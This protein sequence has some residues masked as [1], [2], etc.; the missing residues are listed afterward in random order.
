[1]NKRKHMPGFVS[2]VGAGP[3]DPEL[4]T[5]KAFRRLQNADLVLYDALVEA[6]ILS[7]APAAQR[8]CVGKRA[9]H[10]SVSQ[11]TIEGLLIRGAKTGKQVVRLKCG[12]PFVLGRGGEE[13]LAL[14]KAGVPFEIIPGLTSA[15]AA[16]ALAGV[17]VTH[18]GLSSGFVVISGHA[19][20]A[21]GRILDSITP[22]SLTIILL[23]GLA[24]RKT[25]QSR[26]IKSGWNCCTHTAI[27]L[28]AGTKDQYSWYGRLDNLAT[29]NI[30]HERHLPGTIIIGDVVGLH[31]K[32]SNIKSPQLTA[33]AIAF[34]S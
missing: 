23:M 15:T 31:S 6:E 16:P 29:A 10:K 33:S 30:P 17:P 3:G 32:T 12:D 27:V 34:G 26:L 1:M 7:I 13:A 19:E 20:S 28:A 25:I 5:I 22:D 21:Y 11:P 14:Q 2:L 4:L 8:F 24:S 9:G 18:R